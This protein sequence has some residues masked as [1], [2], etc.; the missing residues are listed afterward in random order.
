VAQ[1]TF[2]SPCLF[3][4]ELLSAAPASMLL[5]IYFTEQPTRYYHASFPDVYCWE[6]PHLIHVAVACGA[7]VVF[8]GM[9]GMFTMVSEALSV[10]VH[11]CFTCC[12]LRSTCAAL[13]EHST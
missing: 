10:A 1:Q 5:Q 6:M 4:S 11:T 3:W 7:L 13:L 12:A 9:A 2:D 8:L